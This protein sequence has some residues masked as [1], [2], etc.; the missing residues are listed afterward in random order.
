MT[1]EYLMFDVLKADDN[2]IETSEIQADLFCCC[3][4][5]GAGI[6]LNYIPFCV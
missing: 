2:F 6:K 5:L 4:F 1:T 3:M